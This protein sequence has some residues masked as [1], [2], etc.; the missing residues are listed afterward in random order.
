MVQLSA[1][2]DPAEV[3][4][5][6]GGARERNRLARHRSYLR[7]AL[8]VISEEGLDALTMQRLAAEVGASVGSVYTYFSSKGALVAEVQRE[9]VE[10]LAASAVRLGGEVDAVVAGEPAGVALLTPVVAFGRWWL[11][12]DTTHPE[13]MRLLLLL[14]SDHREVVPVDEAGRVVPAA[15]RLLALAESR[16]RAAADAGVLGSWPDGGTPEQRTVALAAALTG[17]LQ[18]QVVQ[19]WDPDLLDP[20]ATGRHVLDALLLGWG[21]EPAAVAAAH[22]LVD[23]LEATGPLARPAT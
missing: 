15:L 10:R 2:P 8:R 1:V 9:A 13:E 17:C 5:R 7:A 22:H 6:A 11:T 4:E 14:L 21:A 16:L 23:R 20:R 3:P 19:R 18:L 12:A